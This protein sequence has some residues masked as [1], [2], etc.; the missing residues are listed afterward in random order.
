MADN[1]WAAFGTLP[2]GDHENSVQSSI[3]RAL[4]H[5]CEQDQST[6]R[7][8]FSEQSGNNHQAMHTFRE[9]LVGV[10][11]AQQEY[12]PRY[13][14][15]IDGLTPDWHFQRGG[16]DE[17]IADVV[18][19]HVER[20]IEA[21]IDRALDEGQTWSGT[22]PDQVQRLHSSLWKKAGKYKNLAAEK[23][24]PYVVFSFGWMNAIV[25]SHQ[26]EECLLHA[27]GLFHDYPTLSG[28][29]H[30]YEKGHCLFDRNAGYRFDYYPN[31]KATYLAR[32]LTNGA[33][34]YRFPARSDQPKR[35]E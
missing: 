5:L 6:F 35:L 18:N 8:K 33:L 1:I 20:K 27:G 3:P 12:K 7:K 13:E 22:I 30:M 2:V 21:Q 34:P 32:W 16:Q 11:M 15:N 4:S 14:P 29:Y 17:F 24:V 19:F 25:Q 10:F 26:L 31:L 9:L 28:V 23:G